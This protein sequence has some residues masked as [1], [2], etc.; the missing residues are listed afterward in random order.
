MAGWLMGEWV[1]PGQV[2][3]PGEVDVDD[4][5]DVLDLEN[6]AE[7]DDGARPG[8]EVLDSTSEAPEDGANDLLVV[9]SDEDMETPWGPISSD[10]SEPE[11][12]ALVPLAGAGAGLKRKCYVVGS[13]ALLT[14]RG[15]YFHPYPSK[16]P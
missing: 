16:K 2:E 7:H 12:G 14:G 5:G 13:N 10:D 3:C 15:K 6:G 1:C 4:P 11:C 9:I 8:P